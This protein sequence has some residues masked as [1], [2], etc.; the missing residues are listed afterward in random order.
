MTAAGDLRTRVTFQQLTETPDGYGGVTRAWSAG[1]VVHCQYRA[2][3]GREQVEAG[4][5]EASA[6]ATLRARAASINALDVDE[7][8]RCEIGGEPWNVKSVV[9][10]GQRGEWADLVIERA[11]KDA[12]V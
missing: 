8:W 10:F 9:A 1:T 3:S 7:S 4:R 6:T 5:I 11:G 2:V 12:A